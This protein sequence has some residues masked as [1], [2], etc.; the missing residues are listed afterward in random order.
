M[1]C[2]SHI[3]RT[4]QHLPAQ[5]LFVA[6]SFLFPC[7]LRLPFR[8]LG[9]GGETQHPP[10][11]HRTSS[12]AIPIEN[13]VRQSHSSPREKSACPPRLNLFKT[14]SS[15]GRC[16]ISKTALRHKAA[17]SFFC[18]FAFGIVEAIAKEGLLHLHRNAA[19][20]LGRGGAIAHAV[21]QYA[22][23]L[24]R[25]RLRL[26]ADFRVNLERSLERAVLRLVREL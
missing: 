23:H 18:F 22:C 17:F 19:G 2:D 15:E 11:M 5:L 1:R 7:R 8:N 21:D 4:W 13:Q 6:L 9:G 14:Q 25:S 24:H 20:L 16:S 10:P 3:R 26:A 12:N